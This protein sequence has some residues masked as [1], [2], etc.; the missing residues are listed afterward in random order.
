MFV[1]RGRVAV[2]DRDIK[3]MQEALEG[4]LEEE[5]LDDLGLLL[6]IKEKW[7]ELAGEKVA[8][9]TKPYRLEAG[10]LYVGAGSHALAQ[11]LHFCSEDIR[12]SIN[13]SLG[14]DIKSIIIKKINLK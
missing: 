7:T 2:G 9:K 10:K 4:L 6:R 12:N 5:G 14:T 13:A 1:T 11:N 8:A 3:G